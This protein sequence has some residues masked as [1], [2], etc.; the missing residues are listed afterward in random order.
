MVT[1]VCQYN[2]KFLFSIFSSFQEVYLVYKVCLGNSEGMRR[3]LTSI[4]TCDRVFHIRGDHC[5]SKVWLPCTEKLCVSGKWKLQVAVAM[6]QCSVFQHQAKIWVSVCTVETCVWR[7]LN[8]RSVVRKVDGL[9]WNSCVNGMFHSTVTV[10][11]VLT[12]HFYVFC[13]SYLSL[14]RRH[15]A[16]IT[17]AI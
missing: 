2:I 3:I 4:W 9:A 12:D 10:L 14:V 16:W 15:W 5:N 11:I 8:I 1:F 13:V 17:G 6:A 7:S